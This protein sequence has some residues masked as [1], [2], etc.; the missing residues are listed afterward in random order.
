VSESEGERWRLRKSSCGTN[1]EAILQVR[2]HQRGVE[3]RLVV[4]GDVLH[5]QVCDTPEQAQAMAEEW[6]LAMVGRGWV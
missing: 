1:R 2:H 6:K 3:L 5:A 4:N